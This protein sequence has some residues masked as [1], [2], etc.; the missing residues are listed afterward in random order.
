MKRRI[1]RRG[2]R[3][4]KRAMRMKSKRKSYRSYTVARGGIRL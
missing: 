3:P 2:Y 1:K 4:R